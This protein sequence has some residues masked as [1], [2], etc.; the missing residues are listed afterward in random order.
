[1]IYIKNGH[2]CHDD[3]RFKEATVLVSQVIAKR[4]D[5]YHNI[6]ASKLNNPKTSAKAYWSVLK[7]FY[8]GKEVPVIPPVLIYNDIISDF[9]MKANHFHSFLLPTVPH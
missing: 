5:D 7:T 4:K 1:M 6:I 2:K 9:K 3:P 8:N